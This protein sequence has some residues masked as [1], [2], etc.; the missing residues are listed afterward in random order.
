MQSAG[1]ETLLRYQH[2]LGHSTQHHSTAIENINPMPASTSPSRRLQKKGCFWKQV[3]DVKRHNV[4]ATGNIHFPVSHS[5]ITSNCTPTL[6]GASGWH[7]K[8]LAL[9][10]AARS[11]LYLPSYKTTSL[12]MCCQAHPQP[13]AQ[14]TSLEGSCPLTAQCHCSSSSALSEM[15]SGNH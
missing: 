2:C 6:L 1:A 13:R 3:P 11:I 9:L 10:R 8:K 12:S 4:A 15:T 14:G 5:Q 7:S